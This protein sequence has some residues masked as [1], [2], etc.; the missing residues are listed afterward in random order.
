M[1]S[2]NG[3]KY[4]I[5][6]RTFVKIC[7]ASLGFFTLGCVEEKPPT[8]TQADNVTPQPTQAPIPTE[9]PGL[10]E[11]TL[12]PEMGILNV[13][14]DIKMHKI[15]YEKRS[16]FEILSKELW[17]V[18]FEEQFDTYELISGKARLSLDTKYDIF[19]LDKTSSG[20]IYELIVKSSPKKASGTGK[21]LLSSETMAL[22]EVVEKLYKESKDTKAY[23]LRDQFPSDSLPIP[24][25]IIAPMEEKIAIRYLHVGGRDYVAIGLNT[26]GKNIYDDN[27]ASNMEEIIAGLG[28]YSSGAGSKG[29]SSGG[30]TGGG[31]RG[32]GGE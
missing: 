25:A 13:Y 26:A 27:S 2:D 15:P 10:E 7:A 9:I 8:E 18:E 30:V 6:R 17:N 1:S 24:P 21:K 4:M 20:A 29:T 31:G 32:R 22:N 3:N 5:T 19:E 14:G 11:T 23:V 12:T 16:D 28:L